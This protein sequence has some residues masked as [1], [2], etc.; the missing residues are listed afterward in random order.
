MIQPRN[1]EPQTSQ[2]RTSNLKPRNLEPRTLV[3]TKLSRKMSSDGIWK[4]LNLTTS[5]P[6]NLELR[7]LATSN[8]EPRNLA[9][10]QPRNSE[11]L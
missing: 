3:H 5:Q 4:I 6:H 11:T 7:N 9:T 1:L 2:P 8:L 10:S